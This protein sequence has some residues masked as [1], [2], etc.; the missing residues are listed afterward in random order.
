MGNIFCIVGKSS[1]GKDTIYK[2]VMHAAE[3]LL[4]IIPY[5]TRPMREGETDGVEYHFVD[6]A[7]K[8]RMEKEGRIIEI[9]TYETIYG[10]WDYFTADDGSVTIAEN[11]YLVIG[12]LEALSGLSSYYPGSVVPLY[13]EVEDGERLS[14]AL[15][16]EKQQEK[17]GYEEMCR[18]FLADQKDFSEEKLAACGI[19]KRFVNLDADDTAAQIITYIENVSK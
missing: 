2:K 19:S 12:T 3:G 4:P 18:R 17:P 6:R 11:N 14:R 16:R 15:A 13:I 9:R 7:A 1:T 5:T 10:P 8:D